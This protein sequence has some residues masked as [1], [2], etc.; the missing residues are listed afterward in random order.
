MGGGIK[1]PFP[2]RKSVITKESKTSSLFSY[3]LKNSHSITGKSAG[4]I[5]VEYVSG[6]R[7]ESYLGNNE[8]DKEVE[9]IFTIFLI[10]YFFLNEKFGETKNK[11]LHNFLYRLDEMIKNKKDSLANC[12]EFRNFQKYCSNKPIQQYHG[13]EV[14]RRYLTKYFSDSSGIFMRLRKD[15]WVEYVDQF[16]KKK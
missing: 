8:Q 6:N 12:S 5:Q 10:I 9:N 11:K 1:K 13:Y 16:L 15:E 2:K 7:P 3:E 14:V 4:S